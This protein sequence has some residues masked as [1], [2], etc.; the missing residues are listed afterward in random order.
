M[1]KITTESGLVLGPFDTVQAV[2]GDGF[3]I[4][5]NGLRAS[6]DVVVPNSTNTSIWMASASSNTTTRLTR[7][8]IA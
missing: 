2:T 3:G 7:L 1:Q 6:S 5:T 8:T 4:A